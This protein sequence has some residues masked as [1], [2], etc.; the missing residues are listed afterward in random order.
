MMVAGRSFTLID[1]SMRPK[2]WM[3]VAKG[4]A[5]FMVV[6]FHTSLYFS[7]AEITN[8]P[9]RIKQF[10]ESFPMPAF[11]LLS[12]MFALRVGTWTFSQVWVRRLFP[13]LWLY[14]VWS[15]VRFVFYWVVPGTNGDLGALQPRTRVVFYSCSSG[16]VTAIGSCTPC[17]GS[18][19]GSGRYVKFPCG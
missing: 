5:M 8:F 6:F 15:L 12:G 9:G 1:R 11:M 14:V 13:L 4:V 17:S 19:W 18:P 3:D 7:E 10:L 2:A 16:P